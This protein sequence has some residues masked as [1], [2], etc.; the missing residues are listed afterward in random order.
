MSTLPAFTRNGLGVIHKPPHAV[1]VGRNIFASIEEVTPEWAEAALGKLLPNQRKPKMIHLKSLVRDI[2]NDRFVFTGEPIIFSDHGHLVD[3]SHRCRAVI[4][5][6]TPIT[7]LVIYGVPETSFAAM[8]NSAKRSGADAL[9]SEHGSTNATNTAAVCGLICTETLGL[10]FYHNHAH[11]PQSIAGVYAANQE[12]IDEAVSHGIRL[13]H[14][15]HGPSNFAYCFYKF[16]QIDNG[17]AIKMFDGL[18]NGEG[19]MRGD[20]VLTLR[21]FFIKS[22]TLRRH[23]TIAVVFM[24]WNAIRGGKQMLSVRI[25]E[26]IPDLI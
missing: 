21:N 25:P 14:L 15:G 23:Q 17:T 26:E 9:R 6:E 24:A 1:H 19:L 4:A 5:A 22:A 7:A 13:K 18:A 20:P 11:S 8:N 12:R 10:P 2:T 3:G 16:A